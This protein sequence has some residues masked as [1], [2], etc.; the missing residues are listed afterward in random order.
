[1]VFLPLLKKSSGN[2]SNLLLR[3]AQD[4]GKKGLKHKPG[5]NSV[6][7]ISYLIFHDE[8]KEFDWKSFVHNDTINTQDRGWKSLF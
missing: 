3:L 8:V 7:H 1:M 2:F 5:K 6:K 4:D